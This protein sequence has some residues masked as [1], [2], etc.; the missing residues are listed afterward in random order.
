MALNERS[1]GAR[2][3]SLTKE[4]HRREYR[5]AM[6][7]EDKYHGTWQALNPFQSP[8]RLSPR[9]ARMAKESS[10]P[11]IASPSRFAATNLPLIPGKQQEASPKPPSV[12]QHLSQRLQQLQKESS[13]ARTECSP[14]PNSS[15]PSSN[16]GS[17][18]RTDRRTFHHLRHSDS[19]DAFYSKF[20]AK[21]K[22]NSI[23]T[24]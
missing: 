23:P 6:Q 8:E 18:A 15:S 4:L 20:V 14:S 2:L 24:L 9:L 10:P 11:V 17:A 13:P 7:W 3:T 21:P 22:Y 16:E 12:T 1:P 5:T 19:R